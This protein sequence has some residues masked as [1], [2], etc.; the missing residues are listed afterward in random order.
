MVVPQELLNLIQEDANL[1]VS[2]VRTLQELLSNP[3]N[4]IRVEDTCNIE[5]LNEKLTVGLKIFEFEGQ[6]KLVNFFNH[7]VL[8]SIAIQADFQLLNRE[9]FRSKYYQPIMQHILRGG[10][11]SEKGC[12]VIFR[13]LNLHASG[14]RA[15]FRG[16]N[17]ICSKAP[18][19][20][21]IAEGTEVVISI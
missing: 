8:D 5:S 6:I 10:S 3:N 20:F 7:D 9:Q 12:K 16:M 11:L 21:N 2:E 4:L 13:T 19:L 18:S 17:K 1:E 15:Y 14:S